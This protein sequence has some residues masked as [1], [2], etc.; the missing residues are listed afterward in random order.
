MS[1]TERYAIPSTDGPHTAAVPLTAL[2]SNAPEGARATAMLVLD[3]GEIDAA[4]RGVLVPFLELPSCATTVDLGPGAGG[5]PQV[6]DAY[7]GLPQLWEDMAQELEDSIADC[8]DD[9]TEESG[10]SLGGRVA[11]VEGSG[12]LNWR[13]GDE[14]DWWQ[15]ETEADFGV[16]GPEWVYAGTVSGDYCFGCVHAFYNT[17]T[18]VV[19]NIFECT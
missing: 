19:R 15:S 12:V 8:E 17:A 7:S 5:K 2:L 4:H 18:K 1:E 13:H 16:D 6:V 9:F 10:I 3:L 11:L 14:V